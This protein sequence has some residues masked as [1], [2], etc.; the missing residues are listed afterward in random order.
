MSQS[1]TIFLVDDDVDDCDIFRF[2]LETL[3]V[4]ANLVC[5]YDGINAL[6]Q[7]AMPDFERPDLILLDL[8]M[9]RMDGKQLLARL[10]SLPDYAQAPIVV[11]S[12]SAAP[13]DINAATEGGATVFMTKHSSLPRMCEDLQ[14]LLLRYGFLSTPAGA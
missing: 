2:A 14:T 1:K 8:N 6:E 7:M 9:P 12:T 4:K 11:Y 5:A 10:R 13:A 3:Q